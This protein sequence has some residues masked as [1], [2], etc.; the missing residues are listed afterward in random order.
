MK[1]L[2]SHIAQ[3]SGM[4]IRECRPVSGGDISSAFKIVSANGMTCFLK[5]NAKPFAEEMFIAEKKGL[6]AIRQTNT[7]AVPRVL[8]TGKIEDKSFLLM[9]YIESKHPSD[10]D[11]R[12]LGTNLA[13]LHLSSTDTFGFDTDNFIG[14]LPQSNR[15]HDNW[16]EFYWEERIYPQL[17]K[18]LTQHLIDKNEIPSDDRAV[19]LF[20]AILGAPKPALVHGDL[21]GGNYL[22]SLDERPVLIDPA[23]YYG[24][25]M[26]DIA[27]TRLFGGFSPAF[28]DAYHEIIPKSEHYNTQVELYQLYYLLVHLNLFGSGYYSSVSSILR[29]YF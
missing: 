28:Y 18:A 5:V 14:S 11:F 26:A 19:P 4:D 22:I 8:L 17:K 2:I 20:E 23:V 12:R 7:I 27:M 15:K 13:Q 24:H 21:W 10:S 9:E 6:E 29:R 3:E 1:S 25:S 16:A